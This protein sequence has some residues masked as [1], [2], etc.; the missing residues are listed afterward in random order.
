MIQ[1]EQNICIYIN[2][3][4]SND[5]RGHEFQKQQREFIWDGMKEGI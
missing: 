4:S 5:K 2:I 3:I 1:T